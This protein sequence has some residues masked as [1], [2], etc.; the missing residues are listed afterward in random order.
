MVQRD[1]NK[2]PARKRVRGHT[3]EAYHEDAEGRWVARR[4]SGWLC[5]ASLIRHAGALR[6]LPDLSPA[7]ACSQR[8]LPRVRLIEY[9][10]DRFP[11]N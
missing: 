8:P 6:M 7:A 1:N 2:T 5:R 3:C 9:P 11:P 10:P 4:S